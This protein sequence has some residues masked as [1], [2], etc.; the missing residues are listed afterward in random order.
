MINHIKYYKDISNETT[1]IFDTFSTKSISLPLYII[2][3]LLEIL[4]EIKT[5]INENILEIDPHN[6]PRIIISN[7]SNTSSSH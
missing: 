3:R 5:T 7:L 1:R 4:L 6:Q 2:K